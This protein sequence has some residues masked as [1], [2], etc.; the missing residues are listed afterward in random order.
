M[1]KKIISIISITVLISSLTSCVGTQ[2]FG[3]TTEEISGQTVYKQ[4]EHTTPTTDVNAPPPMGVSYSD[5]SGRFEILMP[6]E[7]WGSTAED[8]GIRFVP[9]DYTVDVMS[10]IV[11]TESATS[12]ALN[13]ESIK[14]SIEEQCSDPSFN[15]NYIGFSEITVSGLPAYRSDYEL[16]VDGI[17]THQIQVIVQKDGKT[18]YFT[19]CD[20]TSTFKYLSNYEQCITSIKL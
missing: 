4:K 13:E 8:N 14:S 18:L 12:P 2:T 15:F 5:T 9:P 17:R 3:G 6:S 10:S 7:G 16:T 11:F 1:V 19:F 20:G